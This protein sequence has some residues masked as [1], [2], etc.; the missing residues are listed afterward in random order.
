MSSDYILS[1]GTHARPEDGRCAME[2]VSHL[3]GEPHSDEPSC[4]SPVLRA[5]CIAL[6][7]GLEHEPRQRLRPYLARTIGTAD[8]GLD[9]ERGWM[10]MDWLIRVYTPAWLRTAGLVEAGAALSELEPVGHAASLRRALG[11]LDAARREARAARARMFGVPHPT[12]WAASVAAGIAGREAAWACA[13]AAAWAAARVSIGD[14]AGDRA[15]AATRATAGDAAAIAVRQSRVAARHGGAREAAR[16]VLAP[17]LEML[18][19][20]ALDLLGR[21]LPTEWLELPQ[22]ARERDASTVLA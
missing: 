3:A 10:A 17:T 11:S 12:G 4:V 5:M 15:R 8:D 22:P 13:G 2:W 19:G 18:T 1:Y 7:D 20:S 9:T 6:N 16:S 14:A 21:M